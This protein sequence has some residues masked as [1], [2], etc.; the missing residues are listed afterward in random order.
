MIVWLLLNA[1]CTEHS[2][3]D[4]LQCAEQNKRMN[5]WHTNKKSF[6]ILQQ[7]S[8]GKR[9]NRESSTRFLTSLA[10][11]FVCLVLNV[12]GRVCVCVHIEYIKCDPYDNL[13]LCAQHTHTHAD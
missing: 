9:T 5:Q 7:K 10:H 4:G 11:I 3:A 13:P 1:K 6:H 12:D 2:D 8:R